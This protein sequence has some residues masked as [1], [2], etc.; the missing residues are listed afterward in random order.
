[1][2]NLKT[3]DSFIFI[4]WTR[5]T[6][7]SNHGK[8]KAIQSSEPEWKIPSGFLI[9]CTMLKKTD[10][11]FHSKKLD[12]DLCGTSASSGEKYK[13][14]AKATLNLADYATNGFCQTCT[15]S[16]QSKKKK[17]VMGLLTIEIQANWSQCDGKR[18]TKAPSDLSNINPERVVTMEGEDYILETADDCSEL[19][20]LSNDSDEGSESN[21][22]GDDS[23][24]D[25]FAE[26]SE[27]EESVIVEVKKEEPKQVIKQSESII[28]PSKEPQKDVKKKSHLK[29]LSSKSSSI[30]K[31]LHISHLHGKKES[32]KEII[33]PTISSLYFY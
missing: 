29:A 4:K 21:V 12:L 20:E 10:T 7:K 9:N 30:K 14:I 3:S 5:G 11:K 1:M 22:F 16:M 18:I 28:S 6:K 15:L 27:T 24:D 25:P 8:T 13:S 31:A 2:D 26:D 23:E 33:D 17:K 19:S 32:S